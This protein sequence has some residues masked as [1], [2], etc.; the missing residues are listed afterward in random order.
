VIDGQ[1]NLAQTTTT[2]AET[3]PANIEVKETLIRRLSFVAVLAAEESS[4]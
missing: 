2:K 3:A 4:P 1:E